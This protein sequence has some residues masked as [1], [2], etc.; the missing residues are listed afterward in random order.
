MFMHKY[1]IDASNNL[2]LRKIK[3]TISICRNEDIRLYN[4]N[5]S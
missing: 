3:Q 5:K 4:F 2:I 1:G